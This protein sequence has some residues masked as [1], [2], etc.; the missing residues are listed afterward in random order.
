MWYGM[1]AA[2]SLEARKE[3]GIVQSLVKYSPTQILVEDSQI[4]RPGKVSQKRE[5]LNC[6]VK[7]LRRL[8]RRCQ[9]VSVALVHWEKDR[10]EEES[11]DAQDEA[12]NLLYSTR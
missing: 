5:A 4:D 11:F 6:D 12:S 7:V 8:Q 9:K 10:D 3:T 1:Q 2:C